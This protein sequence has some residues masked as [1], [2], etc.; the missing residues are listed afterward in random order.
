MPLYTKQDT[1][2]IIVETM[3]DLDC[4]VEAYILYVTPKGNKGAW[5]AT[6]DKTRLV[7][8]PNKTELNQAG[9]WSLQAKVVVKGGDVMLGQI[10]YVNVE[11]SLG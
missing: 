3:Y 11:E 5:A 9:M 6:V 2:A 1:T 7:Y 4:A 10:A 8:K